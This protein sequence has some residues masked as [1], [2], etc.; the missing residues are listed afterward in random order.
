MLQF[1]WLWAFAFLPLPWL[2]RRFVSP[3][4]NNKSALRVPFL[5]R[6]QR[7][8]QSSR[9]KILPLLIAALAWA[10]L[11]TATA[12]PQWIQEHT[13]VP[14]SGRD[15]MM[16]LDISDSMNAQDFVLGG[17][18]T[19]RLA[20]AKSVA[21]DFIEARKGDRIGIVIYA[22]RPAL[23][24]PLSFDID[25]ARDFIRATFIGIVDQRSTA[26]GDAIGFTLKHLLENKDDE[27]E[28]AQKV[29][30][31]LTDGQNNSGVLNPE[32]AADLAANNQMKIY[33]IGI[34]SRRNRQGL[35]ETTLKMIANKTGGRYFYASDTRGLQQVYATIDQLESIVREEQTFLT[36]SALFFWPLSLAA[37]LALGLAVVARAR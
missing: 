23:Q 13:R 16:A 12:R 36:V 9:K 26:I 35:D 7:A 31:L 22:S 20:A 8:D 17:R 18:R 29:L 14:Q 24:M 10:L 5:S 30:I 3:S 34:G 21:I 33:T 4:R 19:S 6:F 25:T 37:L 11:I 28:D 1:E 32:D 27:E 2:V 15:L